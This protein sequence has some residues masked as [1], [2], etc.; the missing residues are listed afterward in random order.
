MTRERRGK[1]P[2][3]ETERLV[4]R[5]PLAPHLVIQPADRRF[6]LVPRVPFRAQVAEIRRMRRTAPDRYDPAILD[7]RQDAAADAAVAARSCNLASRLDE[8]ESRL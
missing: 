8:N 2:G 7:A 3:D 6:L 4:P 5:L 1:F